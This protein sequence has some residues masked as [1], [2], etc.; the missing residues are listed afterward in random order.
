M[1]DNRNQGHGH[2]NVRPDGVKAR[3]G[4]PAL[5]ADCRA[6]LVVLKRDGMRLVKL[7]NDAQPIAMTVF[8]DR[9]YIATTD[10]VYRM[11]TEYGIDHFT[12]VLFAPRE[13]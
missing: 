1:D 2:V 12:P 13:G 4:G 8:Q 5:C 3:C 7:P 11:K 6:D 10:G 9:L